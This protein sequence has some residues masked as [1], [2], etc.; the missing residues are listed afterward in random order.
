METVCYLIDHCTWMSEA[1][2]SFTLMI[3]SERATTA[4]GELLPL[5]ASYPCL[6]PS[7]VIGHPEEN[8]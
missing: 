2:L 4:G 5:R 6:L 1:K 8:R 3:Q 7:K